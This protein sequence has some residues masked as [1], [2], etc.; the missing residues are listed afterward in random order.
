MLVAL[1][2]CL[3]L[4]SEKTESVKSIKEY[5]NNLEISWEFLPPYG[6]HFGGLWEAAVKSFNH[7]YRRVLGHSALTFEEHSTLPTHI[8]SYLNSRPVF[9]ISLDSGDPIP[10][11]PG[12][13]LVGRR[14]L[15]PAFNTTNTTKTY[16]QRSNLILAMR[17]SFWIAWK[18]EVLHQLI[19]TNKWK[20]PKE[21]WKLVTL[22]S[23][24]AKTPPPLT[25]P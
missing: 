6:P 15:P 16:T 18:K 14:T 22:S 24:R 23:S 21:T 20:F 7:H 4:F 12:H 10:L 25:G 17:N 1:R 9:T 2:T 19:Q 3:N 11:T 8:E 5:V 13:F